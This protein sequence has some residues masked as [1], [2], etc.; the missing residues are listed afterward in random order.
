MVV[1]WLWWVACIAE[2][3]YI[4][5]RWWTSQ[6]VHVFCFVFVFSSCDFSPFSWIL[7]SSLQSL[8]Y[9]VKPSDDLHVFL[10]KLDVMLTVV[11]SEK[12]PMILRAHQLCTVMFCMLF[13]VKKREKMF[14]FFWVV[15]EQL[16]HLEARVGSHWLHHPA[17]AV[18]CICVGVDSSSLYCTCLHTLS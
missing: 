4:T 5:R 15:H 7:N 3:S 10:W 16:W 14:L 6:D 17:W 11:V 18:L 8:V 9:P 12:V 2:C 13:P 1:Y